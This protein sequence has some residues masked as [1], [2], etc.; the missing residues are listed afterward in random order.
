MSALM[1]VAI[2][3]WLLCGIPAALIAYAKKR[4]VGA[5]AVM[6]AIFG[7]FGVAMIAAA[8]S[9]GA[10]AWDAGSTGDGGGG[11]SGCGGG[12]SCGGGGGC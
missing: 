8:Q 7:V 6:G 9:P 2:A 3:V 5:W 10:G 11:F 4:N 12:S 1:I